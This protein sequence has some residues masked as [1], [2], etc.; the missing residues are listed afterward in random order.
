MPAVVVP[1][2]AQT[3]PALWSVAAA[4]I[5]IVFAIGSSLHRR[6]GRHRR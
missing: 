2:L 4:G 5:A 3:D 6:R 1:A